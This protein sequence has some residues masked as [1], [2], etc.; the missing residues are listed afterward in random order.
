MEVIAKLPTG[1]WLWPAIWL[2]PT[3]NIYGG[4]PRSGEI[5]VMESRGNPSYV[6]NDGKQI[7]VEH[8]GSTLHFGPSWDKNGYW[9]ATYDS[10]S[11]P[12]NGYNNDFHKYGFIWTPYCLR[13]LVD[14]FEV[15]TVA[16]DDGF[17]ARGKFEGENI[18]QNA[19]KAAPFDQEVRFSFSFKNHL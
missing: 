16:V 14:D 15:G 18:W 6:N 1:D 9:S 4:W 13:F 2:L 7:G 19:T 5:D 8:F 17:W 12:G 3:E 10:N 11:E